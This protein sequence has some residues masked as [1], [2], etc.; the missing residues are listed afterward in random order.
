MESFSHDNC[1]PGS[2]GG[3]SFA[4]ALHESV[5]DGFAAAA[6]AVTG[7]DAMVMQVAK[8]SLGMLASIG[9]TPC[10][11][12][13]MVSSSVKPLHSLIQVKTDTYPP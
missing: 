10:E 4:S 5:R 7:R 13:S 1:Q 11:R 3:N 2:G 8:V 6:I 9:Q 12:L